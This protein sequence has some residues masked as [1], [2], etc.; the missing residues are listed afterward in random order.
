VSKDYANEIG[1]EALL[2]DFKRYQKQTPRGV[3]M[4]KK[5]QN[6]YLQFKTPN[7]ARKQYAC[8]CSFTLD[9]MVDA[10][11]KSNKVAKALKSFTSEAEFW[12]WYDKEI[13]EESQLQDDL[14]TFG[15]AIAL[16]EDDFWERLY[17]ITLNML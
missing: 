9:G 2:S 10:L 12:Q 6:I 4:A 15:E 11:R 5:G 8:G 7:T 16:V 13:K 3:G 14:I 17:Q 1:Y